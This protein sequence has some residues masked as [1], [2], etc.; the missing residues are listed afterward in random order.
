MDGTTANICEQRPFQIA[1][2]NSMEL[3]YSV[4]FLKS[5]EIAKYLSW[6]AIRPIF[7]YR[8]WQPWIRGTYKVF[9]T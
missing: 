4:T 1:L 3:N 5:K 8:E 9:L 2:N 7:P 6:L